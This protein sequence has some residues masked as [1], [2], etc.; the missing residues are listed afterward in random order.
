[1]TKYTCALFFPLYCIYPAQAQQPSPP[2]YLDTAARNF[3]R[4]FDSGGLSI[5]ILAAG[6]T[7]SYHF[8]VETAGSSHAPSANTLYE[9]GSITKTF[10]STILAHAVLEHKVRL[11]DDIR[12]Y[13]PGKY[14]NLEYKGKPIQLAH[15]ANLTS[16]LPNWLPDNQELFRH[17]APD[18]IPYALLKLL[19]T[20]SRPDFYG[21]LHKVRLL[22]AP[23]TNPRHS[24]VAAQLLGYL[25]ETIYHKP[26][27]TLIAE[28]I[29][30]PLQMH[31]TLFHPV[32]SPDMAKGYNAKGIVMPEIGLKE[33]Q[34]AGGLVSSTNDMLKYIRYQL[35]DS[36]KVVAL[37]H[38]ITVRAEQDTVALNWHIDG[39]GTDKP[40]IWHTGGTFGFSSYL[41]LLPKQQVG[42]VLM[43]NEC[44]PDTQNRLVKIAK[45][46]IAHLDRGAHPGN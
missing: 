22:S 40:Q 21:D 42:I 13:L 28:Y 8:G 27:S 23:G 34:P 32:Q 25:L 36:N 33:L 31:Q 24:N 20:Y 3:M 43:S 30:T 15:L 1:M 37:T 17:T 7:V 9:I 14:P 2:A 5:G 4:T 12:L 29:T 18:S 26:I 35:N 38:R 19:S 11:S 46:I 39:A 44:D 10:A 6:K 16:G 45:V 41:V